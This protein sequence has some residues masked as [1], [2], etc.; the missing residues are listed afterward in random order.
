MAVQTWTDLAVFVG[1]Y[2]I[3][4]NAKSFDAPTVTVNQLDT[5]ALCDTWEKS[6]GGLKSAAWS[7]SVMQDFDTNAVDQL[8]GMTTLGG[9]FP[10]SVAP[11]GKTSG[12]IAYTFNATHFTYTP[13]SGEP[14]G[15]AMAELS[16]MGTGSVA[17]GTLMNTPATAVTTSGNTTARQLGT[18]GA[19][20]RIYVA[21][22]VL[23]ASGTTPTLDVKV[24]SDD[25]AGFSSPTDRITLTQATGIGSQWSSTT[26]GGSDDYW[27]INYTVGGTTPSFTFAA[28]LGIA[29]A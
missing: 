23:S 8:V 9:T 16:G 12:S 29:A 22:H 15:L 20:Q 25:G 5:T 17:R 14:D 10:I 21:L 26:A 3:A 24:Q 6:I 2:N 28:V 19:G 7:G 13:I 1:G 11:A 4:C 18:V 27:R